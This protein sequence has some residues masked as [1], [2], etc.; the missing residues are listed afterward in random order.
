MITTALQLRSHTC[1]FNHVNHTTFHQY[2]NILIITGKDNFHTFAITK[3][4]PYLVLH[5][6]RPEIS[7]VYNPLHQNQHA[8]RTKSVSVQIS[9]AP[10]FT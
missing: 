4:L 3:K 6:H 2:R 7:D 5:E 10:P 1:S 9:Y 8:R